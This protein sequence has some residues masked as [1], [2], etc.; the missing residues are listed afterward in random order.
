GAVSRRP[1]VDVVGGT[2]C[3]L[4]RPL[5]QPA[6]QVGHA[7]RRPVGSER[8]ALVCLPGRVPVPPH[9][10]AV[11]TGSRQDAPGVVE[12]VAGSAER[13][14]ALKTPLKLCPATGARA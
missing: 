4:T 6:G 8:G 1:Q 12:P 11:L 7:P 13:P 14:P 9:L 3:S 2:L 5:I 10:G